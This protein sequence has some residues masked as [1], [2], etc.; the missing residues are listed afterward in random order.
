MI[1][2]DYESVIQRESAIH[3]G[4][5]Y[6]VARMSFGRRIELMRLVR[7]V[8]M[9]FD[10]QEAAGEAGK[11]ASAILT[12]EVDRLYIRWA[13]RAVDGLLIDGLPATPE[14]LLL[15]GPEELLKEALS[16]VRSECGLG[17]E[18]KKT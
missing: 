2:I 18:E 16:I 13:L 11:M 8:T 3:P 4:V 12:F 17:D 5:S 7:E 6:R 9:K 10:F 1:P 14:T 15:D